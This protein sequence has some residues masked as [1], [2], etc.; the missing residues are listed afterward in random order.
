MA[1]PTTIQASTMFIEYSD[2]PGGSRKSAVCLT[3]ADFSGTTAVN[4]DETHCGVLKAVGSSNN[5][6]SGTAVVDAVPDVTEASY[7][8][9]KTIY[10][11]KTKKY[12]HL[13]N[14]NDSNYHGGYG[15]I[16]A[17]GNQNASG[18]T[19][20]FTFTIDIDGDLDTEATS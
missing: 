18:Q 10:A 14:S 19:S 8:D 16:T 5:Q 15:W 7:E 3:Q 2:T 11:A 20:K 12:W 13:T 4:S 6:F 9:F 1:D 17:L